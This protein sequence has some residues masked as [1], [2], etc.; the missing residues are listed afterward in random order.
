M[1]KYLLLTILL[2]SVSY[3]LFA[4]CDMMAMLTKTG[5]IMP[6]INNGLD[7]YDCPDELFQF[8]QNVSS[9]NDNN[10][11]YGVIYYKDNIPTLFPGQMFHQVGIGT[12]Y[13]TN[14]EEMNNAYTAIS[15]PNLNAS[16]VLGH[17]RNT[18]QGA[19][20]SH[21]FW[22]NADT[23]NDG[24]DDTTFTFQHNGDCSDLQEGML[25]YLIDTHGAGWFNSSEHPS[26]W[27][28][29]SS[30]YTQWIDS[31]L[32]FHFIMSHILEYN[33]DV[34]A[35][36]IAALNYNGEYGN[37]EDYFHNQSSTYKINFV[38]S[39]GNNL[40]AFRNYTGYNLSYKSFGNDFVSLKTD[41]IITGGQNIA[42]HSLV[43][44][45]RNGNITTYNDIF[46]L[47]TR[48]FTSGYNWVSFPR[49]TD[50]NSG[51]G[52]EYEQA[53]YENGL[54]GLFQLNSTGA[55]TIYGFDEIQGQRLGTNTVMIIDYL[56]QSFEDNLFDNMLY[57]HEGYKVKVDSNVDPTVLIVD[58]DRLA[59]TYSLDDEALSAGVY[60]W[61]GYWLPYSQNVDDAF[62]KGTSNDVWQ[63]VEVVK[64]EEWTWM[65]MNS[66]RGFIGKEPK[67]S[68]EIKPLEY[69]KAYLVKFNQ[70][71]DNF[72][73]NDSNMM[74][75]PT[76]NL[77]PQNFTYEEKSDYEV[78][79]LLNIPNGV[80]EI[81]VYE[82]G[83]CLG[84]VV[85]QD[86]A[87]QVLVYSD[88]ANR[89]AGNFT[90]ELYTGSRANDKIKKYEVLNQYSGKYEAKP[91]TAGRNEYSVVR[92]D[93]ETPEDQPTDAVLVTEV[94][95][96][97]PNPFNPTTTIFFSL[98]SEQN[99]ELEIYNSKGQKVKS[100]YSGIAKEG[101]HSVVWNGTDSNKKAVSSGVYFYKLKTQNDTFNCKMLLM[102]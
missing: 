34:T 31:E 74:A 69:G 99:I 32:L 23:D 71:I 57:R 87:E 13:G 42:Q 53:Y 51:T 55:P 48:L 22:F 1:K 15:N 37:F 101:K 95:S 77:A 59:S 6:D 43:K 70:N 73:W 93:S 80:E 20:G 65:D 10:D 86:S 50:Q 8:L 4:E 92:F 78:I 5:Y 46:N 58:G 24:N 60:H 75:V 79:D 81:G 72:Q 35:G 64:A 67:P 27:G 98:P 12:H 94:Y 97:Y 29:S 66:S 21:P 7:D 62:G 85:V 18:S 47:G 11:G 52:Y 9:G 76:K 91:L 25:D 88:T 90:F 61:L 14:P 19:Y 40:Y 56:Y 36:I 30:Y 38:L 44:I 17:A 28:A 54:P 39:D 33:G 89:D 26:N 83:V 68:M 100:I 102:K 2:Y 63:Y 84:A 82:N 41:T 49:L 3:Q 45:P 96:N 16:I